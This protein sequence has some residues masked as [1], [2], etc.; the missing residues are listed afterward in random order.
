M[1]SFS[2]NFMKLIF[3]QSHSSSTG[4]SEEECLDRDARTEG[5]KE[6]IM[7]AFEISQMKVSN[8]RG[9]QNIASSSL[10]STNM[11]CRVASTQGTRW[12]SGLI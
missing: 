7:R 1:E 10:F 3:L 12:L 6:K 5:V 9:E 8:L 2:A 4:K 11:S